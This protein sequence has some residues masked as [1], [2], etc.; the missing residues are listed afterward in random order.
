[1]ALL[2]AAG[3]DVNAKTGEGSCALIMSAGKGKVEEVKILLNNRADV[4]M[5]DAGGRTALMAAE[6]GGHSE[7][8]SEELIQILILAGR[9]TKPG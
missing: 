7:E 6:R 3:S 4:S 1:M 5:T 2:I 8:E 9:R